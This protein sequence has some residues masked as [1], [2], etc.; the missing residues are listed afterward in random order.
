VSGSQP[1]SPRLFLL[2][3]RLELLALLACFTA[4]GFAVAGVINDTIL[5]WVYTIAAAAGA[6]IFLGFVSRLFFRR[7]SFP[8]RWTSAITATLLSL[9]IMGWL[10]QGLVG[11]D[12]TLPADRRP[13]WGA[14]GLMAV[15]IAAST[16]ALLAWTE[17]GA[18]VSPAS[19]G[20]IIPEAQPSVALKKKINFAQPTRD[21]RPSRDGFNGVLRF[22]QMARRDAEI[23]LTGA[24]KYKCP[25]CLQPI[26]A[27][28]PRGV[29]VCP[30]CHTRHHKDCWD[31]TG[32]CQ[33][34]HY[35][36]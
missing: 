27:R 32:M 24:E 21:A 26:E 12:P 16:L 33:V 4:A 9:L 10:T 18:A 31:I 14:L 11:A 3:F 1:S 23:R 19:E 20:E 36:S 34:P 7:F 8:L 17:R 29:V 15:G 25:Y 30:I 28:D 6:G 2:L 5:P 35:H 22:F 13:D